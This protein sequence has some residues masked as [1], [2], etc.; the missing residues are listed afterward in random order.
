MWNGVASQFETNPTL[1]YLLRLPASS[2]F[3]NVT[4]KPT[5]S[6]NSMKKGFI[7]VALAVL[8]WCALCCGSSTSRTKRTEIAHYY[9]LFRVALIWIRQ[10]LCVSPCVWKH[11]HS[12]N[13]HNNTFNHPLHYTLSTTKK[14]K[15]SVLAR[16][17]SD[18]KMLP[19]LLYNIM[20]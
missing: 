2:L 10:P 14:K 4:R 7:A 5:R 8:L 11:P 3:A 12:H 9:T 1:M 18:K 17:K 15:D 20:Q 13:Y 16:V 6:S 19:F